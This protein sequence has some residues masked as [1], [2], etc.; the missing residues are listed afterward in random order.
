R[1]TQRFPFVGPPAEAGDAA[2]H[3]VEILGRDAG[4][5]E[6]ELG[7]GGHL[8]GEAEPEAQ[9][10]EART[11]EL[12]AQDVGNEEV[13][14]TATHV[15]RDFAFAPELDELR[16]VPLHGASD[17]SVRAP[18]RRRGAT[19]YP[20]KCRACATDADLSADSRSAR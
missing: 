2:E 10:H 11:Q 15:P 4:V 20:L 1:A 14:A 18:D 3:A 5:G 12:T 16:S 6:L 13:E 19:C 7:P 9:A 8:L 17:S